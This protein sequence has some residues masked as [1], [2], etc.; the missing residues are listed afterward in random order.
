MKNNDKHPL[1]SLLDNADVATRSY[2]G[3]AMY[4]RNCLGVVTDDL[5]AFM[6]SL[7]EALLEQG[8][9]L[10]RDERFEITQ[11]LKSARWD[12]MGTDIIVYFPGVKYTDEDDDDSDE[13]GQLEADEP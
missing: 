3:R 11:G 5:G 8:D 6:E 13:P 9:D 7:G 2:S 10:N 4:G 12:N 1:Q